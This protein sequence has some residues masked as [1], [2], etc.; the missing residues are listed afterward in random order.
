MNKK[1]LWLDVDDCIL[2]FQGAF[3]KHLIKEGV[4]PDLDPHYVQKE[5]DY[6]CVLKGKGLDFRAM[7]EH[8]IDTGCVSL[9]TLGSARRLT[10]AAKQ[11]GYEVNLITAHP[12]YLTVERLRNLRD[13][14]VHYDH[15]YS[16]HHFDRK[17]RAL[18]WDKG[19]FIADLGF[20][21]AHNV[22]VDDRM[23]TVD[24]FVRRGL[25]VGVTVDYPYNSEV[26]STLALIEG[27]PNLI[28]SPW[29][30]DKAKTVLEFHE[31]VLRTIKERAQ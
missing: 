13:A 30:G 4:A 15:Y 24:K 26:R 1:I 29:M 20:E 18:H 28:V 19:E 31:T 25:G 23:G 16:T 11:L 14:G 3:N 6:S 2:D 9:P 27:N 5:W 12:S 17:G 10:L 21:F 22:F 8:F 7:M